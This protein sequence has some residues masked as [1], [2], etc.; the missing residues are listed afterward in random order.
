LLVITSLQ[1]AGGKEITLNQQYGIVSMQ[2]R[3]RSVLGLGSGL[4]TGDYFSC[5]KGAGGS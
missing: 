1:P 5:Q 3:F 2:P 4:V